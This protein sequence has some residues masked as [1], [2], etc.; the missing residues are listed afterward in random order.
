MVYFSISPLKARM[1]V[2]HLTNINC[3]HKYWTQVL[4]SSNNS[5]YQRF[6]GNL[7]TRVS[8][9]VLADGVSNN[10]KFQLHELSMLDNFF[11]SK[12]SE[13][14]VSFNCIWRI[15]WTVVLSIVTK[16]YFL[17]GDRRDGHCLFSLATYEVS[18]DNTQSW[19]IFILFHISYFHTFP[20]GTLPLTYKIVRR[21]A[22]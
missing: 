5:N 3:C 1:T 20:D 19:N 15:L 11:T 17:V 4:N 18:R 13:T 7:T 14:D 9:L 22:G 12:A 6:Q 8:L 10:I 21:L 2:T 16:R